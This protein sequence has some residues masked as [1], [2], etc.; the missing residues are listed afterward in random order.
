M[1]LTKR[2]YEEPSEEDGRRV[3]IDRLWPRGV[4]KEA[5][6]V[7]EWARD[8][9][10]SSELRIWFGHEP[11][12][13]PR[14]RERYREE[15]LRHSEELTRLALDG[16]RGAVTL[17]FGARDAKHCNATVLKEL[18]EEIAGRSGPRQAATHRRGPSSVRPR[19]SRR[20]V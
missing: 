19:G 18:L 8:L 14:F 13:F 4:R 15:L 17:L 11:A 10:P 20:K 2:V 1:F 3:L 7:D 6:R 9:A 5:A 16:E 12:R